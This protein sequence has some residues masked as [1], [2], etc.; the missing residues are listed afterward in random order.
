MSFTLNELLA[1]IAEIKSEYETVFGHKA[2]TVSLQKSTFGYLLVD[3]DGFGDYSNLKD[4]LSDLKVGKYFGIDQYQG[5]TISILSARKNLPRVRALSGKEFLM[6][7]LKKNNILLYLPELSAHYLAMYLLGMASRYY[8]KEWGEIT[9]GK[10]SG[11]IYVIRKFIEITERKFPNLIL[12]SLRNMEFVFVSP[13]LEEVQ[14]L[15]DT[16]LERV[17]R[18][19]ED[20]ENQKARGAGL[21]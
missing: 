9:E 7:S 16:E 8:P 14:R 6:L 20:K 11:D 4:T 1:N 18:Y 17:Y 5:K 10:K 19:V 12:N 21:F 2:N 15:S 13:T 3:N